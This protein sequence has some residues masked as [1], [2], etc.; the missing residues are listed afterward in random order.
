M[1]VGITNA[2]KS[3]PIHLFTGLVVVMVGF[4][5]VMFAVR[6]LLVG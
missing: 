6:P 1:D 5:V 3:H 2:D 4:T